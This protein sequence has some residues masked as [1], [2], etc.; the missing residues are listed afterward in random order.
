MMAKINRGQINLIKMAILPLPKGQNGHIFTIH[1]MA[2]IKQENKPYQ[3]ATADT[4]HKS[5]S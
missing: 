3:Q 2:A 1:M 5:F 4:F